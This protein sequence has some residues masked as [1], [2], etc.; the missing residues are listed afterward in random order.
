MR[1][2]R[3]NMNDLR[4][5]FGSSDQPRNALKA[6]TKPLMT[7][8]KSTPIQPALKVRHGSV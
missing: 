6:I 4:K 8:K 3:R 1:A 5:V 2:N 7:R